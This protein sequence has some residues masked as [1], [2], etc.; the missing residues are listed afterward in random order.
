VE[1]QYASRY[2]EKCLIVGMD[3]REIK[4]HHFSFLRKV[5]I[6]KKAKSMCITSLP[7]MRRMGRLNYTVYI[8][9]CDDNTR[10]VSHLDE[11]KLINLVKLFVRQNGDLSLVLKIGRKGSK[12]DL[13]FS[14]ISAKQASSLPTFDSVAWN[15]HK[16]GPEEEIIPVKCLLREQD[17]N[18]MELN[19]LNDKEKEKLKEVTT[20]EQI[21]HLGLK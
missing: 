9:Y 7:K 21:R 10:F 11:E 2:F 14:N 4:Y 19:S 3:E 20:L 15:F 17:K 5:G 1:A 18:Y 16:D 13:S 8:G 6:L 12:C